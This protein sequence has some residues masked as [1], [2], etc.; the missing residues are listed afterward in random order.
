[1]AVWRFSFIFAKEKF[2]TFLSDTFP[3]LSKASAKLIV[4]LHGHQAPSVRDA[5]Q[6]LAGRFTT[7]LNSIVSACK[8]KDI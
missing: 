2:T 6:L 7:M 3:C 5:E 1:M 4:G 8:L